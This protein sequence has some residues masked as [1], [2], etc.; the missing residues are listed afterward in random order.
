MIKLEGM[1]KGPFDLM[2][3]LLFIA[4]AVSAAVPLITEGSIVKLPT[5]GSI[6]IVT[7][8]L[9]SAGIS[10]R[11]SISPTVIVSAYAWPLAIQRIAGDIIALGS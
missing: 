5:G 2:I 1:S 10:R 3:T 11:R 7:D 8:S 4:E 6:L 9:A